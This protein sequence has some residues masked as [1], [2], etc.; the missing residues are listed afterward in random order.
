MFHQI[1]DAI[2][3]ALFIWICVCFYMAY[4]HKGR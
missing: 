3:G 2:G 1:W 4:I